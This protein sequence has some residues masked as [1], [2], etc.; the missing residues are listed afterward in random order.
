MGKPFHSSASQISTYELCPR[1][2]ALD[3]I[4][5]LP[6]KPNKFAAQGTALHKIA[7][8]WLR[9]GI[10]PPVSDL[11]ERIT[12][13]LPLL[14][15]PNTQGLQVEQSLTRTLEGIPFKGVID[16]KIPYPYREVPA[17]Y[18]H[19]STTNFKWALT[20]EGFL[21]DPQACLYAWDTIL[22][23]QEQG[24]KGDV[25]DLQ[26]T[27]IRTTGAPKALPITRRVSLSEVMPR[28]TKTTTTALEQKLLRETISSGLE[29]PPDASGCEAY[30]GC[31]YVETCN[32][33]A[34]QRIR[35]IMSQGNAHNAFM[36][37]LEAR[38]A[39]AGQAVSA[40][41]HPAPAEA[42]T[43]VPAESGTVNP[44]DGPGEAPTA[45]EEAP[46]PKAKPSG[47]G[48]RGRP[49]GS[50][51]KKAEPAPAPEEAPAPEPAPAPKP[52]PSPPHSPPVAPQPAIM[53][54]V[55]ADP[56]ALVR[57]LLDAAK[58]GRAIVVM[59][60]PNGTAKTH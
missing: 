19:K 12:P 28:M 50:K 2:W 34:S 60:I 7:E 58:D 42:P 44:P 43:S 14:P 29:L 4:D 46:A 11:G 33:T 5:R 25:V 48:K 38:R 53:A 13:A 6:R 23:S 16:V 49:K 26:W 20:P 45:P 10:L 54:P 39:Q 17:I 56:M 27:Y 37:K 35:S 24:Y 18:D 52:V 40:E 21:D 1:K 30:G 9:D 59:V 55:A 32:L 15:P 22:D 41:P 31:P 57:G 8:E 36:A 47:K 3:K 51:N